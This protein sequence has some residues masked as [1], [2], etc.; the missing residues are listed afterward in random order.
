MP[1]AAHQRHEGERQ[2]A[3]AAERLD[4]ALGQWLEALARKVEGECRRQENRQSARPL[5]ARENAQ[6]V[7][8]RHLRQGQVRH[9]EGDDRGRH[10]KR[11]QGG[12]GLGGAGPGERAHAARDDGSGDA[13]HDGNRHEALGLAGKPGRGIGGKAGLGREQQQ[14]R[15]GENGCRHD[16]ERLALEAAAEIRRYR[17][18]AELAQER[19]QQQPHENEA[20]ADSQAQ[21]QGIEPDAEEGTRHGQETGAAKRA[22]GQ[23][24]SVEE[25]RHSAPANEIV[26]RLTRR[27]QQADGRKQHDGAAKHQKPHGQIGS[28]ELLE[29]QRH[30]HQR[31][32]R[33]Q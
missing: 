5:G 21:A 28:A 24:Q 2:A 14:K 20:G 16:P 8:V 25:G 9:H 22:D 12:D 29:H 23:H 31:R 3:D 1:A 30:Q 10:G 4:E 13:G 26:V 27:G 32:D 15:H 33:Q 17:V 6:D 11:K 7:A 19:R 18:G